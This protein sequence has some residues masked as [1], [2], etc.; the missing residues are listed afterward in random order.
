MTWKTLYCGFCIRER[1][2][3]VSQAVT[4]KVRVFFSFVC[5]SLLFFLYFRRHFFFSSAYVAHKSP[6]NTID[7][8]NAKRVVNDSARSSESRPFPSRA[9][10]SGGRSV[11]RRGA[12]RRR[13]SVGRNAV[14]YTRYLG[15]GR[16]WRS[17][18]LLKI[19]FGSFNWVCGGRALTCHFHSQSKAPPSQ[20]LKLR[21]CRRGTTCTERRPTVR[22]SSPGPPDRTWI[23]IALRPQTSESERSPDEYVELGHVRVFR[24]N[25]KISPAFGRIIVKQGKFARADQTR[26][27]LSNHLQAFIN[28]YRTNLFFFFSYIFKNERFFIYLFVFIIILFLSF[29]L[30]FFP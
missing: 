25:T 17:S 6:S 7:D 2:R 24:A 27:R 30:S 11:R 1:R 10:R 12:F 23:I 29:F 5:F 28:I 9:R 8:G 19:V 16:A 26:T 18:A 3:H 4:T 14:A 22:Q 21:L 15:G 20:K 13:L